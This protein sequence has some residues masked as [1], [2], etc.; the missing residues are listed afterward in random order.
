MVPGPLP[1][2][3]LET[4]VYSEPPTGEFRDKTSV[5]VYTD[6]NT[7]C[8]F[9]ETLSFPLNVMDVASENGHPAAFR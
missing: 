4:A 2:A 5:K 6:E 3:L 1:P 7:Q 8:E 9:V